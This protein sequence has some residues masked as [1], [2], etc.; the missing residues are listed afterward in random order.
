MFIFSLVEHFCFKDLSSNLI[1]EYNEDINE[2]IIN[3][4]NTKL[5]NNENNNLPIKELASAVR[6]FISRYLVG[7][8]KKADIEPKSLLL[9]EL[10][11]PD[12]WNK[13]IENLEELLSDEIKE[14]K[15]TVGQCFKF[16]ELIKEED[17]KEINLDVPGPIKEEN[18]AIPKRKRKQ[19]I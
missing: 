4:I 7:K 10:K 5:L 3:K 18:K 1:K 2:E 11:R 13:K 16:Y 12:L 6:R 17:E 14:Y 8:N 9:H 19:I 15:L